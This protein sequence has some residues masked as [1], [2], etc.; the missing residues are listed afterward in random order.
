ME[1]LKNTFNQY[2]G[3]FKSLSASQRLTLLVVTGL[4]VGGLGY[5]ALGSRSAGYVPAS[6]G[7]NFT[8]EEMQ[9]AQAVLR[10]RG[11][12]DF[13][14]QGG[15]LLVPRGKVD[16]YNAALLEGG[17]LPAGWGAEMEQQFEKQGWFT[18]D[19]QSRLRKEIALGKELRRILRALPDVAD[20]QVIWAR[21]DPKRF[22]GRSPKVTA[23]VNVK[24]RSG[25]E[26]SLQLVQSLRLAVANMISNLKPEDVTIFD[27]QS[28]RSYTGE[29]DGPF[30]GR[31][32]D[33]IKQHTR[34]YKEKVERQLSYI[35]G[36]LVTVDVKVDNLESWVEEQ[37]KFDPKGSIVIAEQNSTHTEDATDQRDRARTGEAPNVPRALTG[38]GGPTKRRK[39]N[40]TGSA[41]TTAAGYTATL[42]KYIAA[43][44]KAVQVSVG[45]PEEYF[46]KVAAKQQSGGGTASAGANA[47]TRDQ[48]LADIKRSV[49]HTVG[50]DPNGDSVEVL[51]YV[52]VDP[53]VPVLES[54]WMET[55]NTLLGRWG[56]PVA[57]GLF[58]LVALWMVKRN[59]PALPR[60]EEEPLPM[61]APP[62]SSDDETP[63]ERP[64]PIPTPRDRLQGVVRDNPEVTAAVLSQW[65]N[66][67]N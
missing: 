14:Q 47:P 20:A 24:P 5:L 67:V 39:T 57:L 49:A 51:P 11:L 4:I 9:N 30:D 7:K 42:K 55:A 6:L 3:I 50:A 15:Q 32:I 40:E 1:A 18:S 21:S 33:W 45:I 28:G 48:I 52:K 62:V 13:K 58:A 26:L 37:R 65:L 27:L 38:A 41:S 34:L 46:Q 2:A 16:R 44:P 43:M 60:I 36:V 17:G 59:M 64:A 29:K 12:T 31:L 66:T 22:S 54:D 10:E 53:E 56:G 61:P 25:G 8:G 35:P 23:T 63:E 19:R